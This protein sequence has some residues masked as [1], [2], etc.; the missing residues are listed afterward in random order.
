MRYI[1]EV[2]GL[3]V[4]ISLSDLNELVD[5]LRTLTMPPVLAGLERLDTPDWFIARQLAVPEKSVTQWK[6]GS[7]N[8][9]TDRQINLCKMLESIIQKYA[10]V[11]TEYEN[12]NVDR[13]FYEVGVLKEHIRCAN[14][15]LIL[16]REMLSANKAKLNIWTPSRKMTEL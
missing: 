16:Q 8:L 11:L 7:V 15:L 2:D 1:N 12:D 3:K 13:P 6:A 5:D 14:K 10:D 9:T 4:V